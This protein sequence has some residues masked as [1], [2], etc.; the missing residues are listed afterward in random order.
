MLDDQKLDVSI[1]SLIL[2]KK[3]HTLVKLKKNHLIINQ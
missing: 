1:S 3:I 2:K